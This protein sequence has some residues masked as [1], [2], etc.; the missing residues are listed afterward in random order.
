MTDAGPARLDPA[1][2]R[3]RPGMDRLLAALG[4]ATGETRIV[5][6]AVR[7]ALL[8]ATVSDID[9]ATR[10]K[11]LE[12]M[13]RL[14][15]AGIKA[16]PTGLAHGTVTAVVAGTPHEVTTLRIDAET[17]GRHARVAFTDDWRADA[18]RRDFTVN[19]L[20]ADPLTGEVHDFFGGIADLRG[21]ILRFIGD[22]LQRIAEDH[23]RILR[24][25]RFSARLAARLD[26]AGLA[27][28]ALRAN[29]LLTLSRERIRD[30][31]QKLLAVADPV[32]TVD[33]MLD[34]GIL[35]PVLP[36]AR[37]RD[38]LAR[39]VAAEKAARVAPDPLRRLAALL[40][41]DPAIA[42][43]VA[44][45]LRLSRKDQARL[46]GAATPGAL[47]AD[48]R[49]LAYRSGAEVALDRMLLA[50][51]PRARDWAPRLAQWRRPRLPLSGKDLIAM[52][53]PPGPQ[54]SQALKAIEA[55][56]LEAG[57]PDRPRVLAIAREVLG[58]A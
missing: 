35:A 46:A 7:D 30:E 49:V 6:G 12:V 55:R 11:P 27:A 45:R 23:L 57:F 5:G 50:G 54:V 52:G 31:L 21:R 4:G 13:A 10:L 47:P 53:L 17:D 34:K 56:W 14:E 9:L 18:A 28:C 43:A 40:P 29:D 16:V 3:A 32:P 58:I 33:M 41:G 25:F 36:E 24:F 39:L 38:R 22:P 37:E 8:G 44:Q 20:Y 19:A 15:A 2:W 26:E 42:E 1:I 51:D 48:P